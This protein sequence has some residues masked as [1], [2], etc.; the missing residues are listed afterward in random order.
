MR[1]NSLRLSLSLIHDLFWRLVSSSKV[2]L[3]RYRGREED[4]GKGLSVLQALDQ[5]FEKFD[6]QNEQANRQIEEASSIIAL[7]KQPVLSLYH[8]IG[9]TEDQP[10]GEELRE[11]KR[12]SLR[13]KMKTGARRE[14]LENSK[15][16]SN[17]ENSMEKDSPSPNISDGDLV[18]YLSKIEQR[19]A[20]VSALYK[21]NVRKSFQETSEREERK[22][23]RHA[24][25]LSRLPSV[26]S[27][28]EDPSDEEEIESSRPLSYKVLLSKIKE[29]SSKADTNHSRDSRYQE[30][31]I[32]D[33]I[34]G[35]SAIKT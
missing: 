35:K 21:L 11:S 6:L 23:P 18:T 24:H 13:E 28:S 7:V 22:R 17:G 25:P 19:V 10:S 15:R 29:E 27:D 14:L 34:S 33:D 2:E 30:D 4:D 32:G 9:C 26:D 1:C 5:R 8:A 16:K 12:T 3:E 31:R 20:E